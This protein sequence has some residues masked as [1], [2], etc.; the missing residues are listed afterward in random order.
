MT[1]YVIVHTMRGEEDAEVFGAYSSLESAKAA[2]RAYAENRWDN[3][4]RF[5]KLWSRYSD[6]SG[7]LVTEDDAWIIHAEDLQS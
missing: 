2:I 5:L 6:P 3:P 1:V 4:E 7:D